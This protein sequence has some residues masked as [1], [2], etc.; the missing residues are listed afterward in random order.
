VDDAQPSL[1]R[2]RLGLALCVLAAVALRMARWERTEVLFNDG[3]VF[4][5]LAER[6]AAGQLETLLQHPFHPLYPLLVAALRALTAP[7]G[8]G[9]ETTGVLVSALAGG[10][11]VLALHGFVRRAFGPREGLVAAFLLA[12]HAGAVDSGGDVQSEALYLALFLAAAAALWRALS[13]ARTGAALAAGAFAG[14]AYLTRP[15]GL[16]VALVGLGLVGVYT[17]RRRFPPRRGLAL[18]VALAAGTAA[19]ALPYIAAL[20]AESGQLQLTRKKS[21][22]WV[23]GS[24]GH[25]GSG[26]LATG[27]PGMEAPKI[28]G[29]GSWRLDVQVGGG[30][31]GGAA[32]PGGGADAAT[33]ADEV[34]PD[35]YDSLVAPPWT[36]RGALAAA[37][38]LL[39][40]SAGA[41][42]PEML[43]LVLAG[44]FVLRGRPGR[45]GG[46]VAAL[47]G[48]YGALLFALAMN[49]GYVSE[50][51]ALP[52]LLLLLGYGA[53]GALSLGRALAR[54]RAPAAGSERRA[55]VATALLLAG[56]AAICLG[57]TLRRG[58]LEDVAER[59][60]A[61]WVRAHASPGSVVAARKR[62][63]AYYAGAPFV[64]L[65]P[66][67]ALGFDRYF[68]DHAV[69]FVVVNRADV[70]EYVGLDDLVELRRLEELERI[71]AEGEVALVYA[72][73]PVEPPR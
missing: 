47:V 33:K 39:D 27:Q 41:L 45:R 5:A 2:E 57:K 61:E 54:L 14:L 7:L 9:L 22:G 10:A 66:K 49:V 15:E 70:E 65:R 24:E 53:V 40:D 59:R 50:R 36:P 20:S 73:H 46:F 16:G 30:A 12:F 1:P 71:E 42:R 13:E 63:V 72:Y 26:G 56:V 68:E 43:A 55:R 32:A 3:P 23:V 64:Q 48:A 6:A 38:D 19:L 17:I 11:A 4:L 25:A 28:P 29:A 62:R 51:H 67:T 21:V 37:R 8:L 58:S 69:R 35:P 60:A 44:V 52:P 34:G 31:S 18:G